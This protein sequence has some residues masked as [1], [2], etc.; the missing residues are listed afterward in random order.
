MLPASLA[1][2]LML[3]TLVAVLLAMGAALVAVSGVFW[4]R[5]AEALLRAELDEE[6]RDLQA[7]LQRH[8]DAGAPI[9]LNRQNAAI[10]DAMPADAAYRVLDRHGQVVIQSRTGSALEALGKPSLRAHVPAAENNAEDI[11][12]QVE[13]RAVDIDGARYDIQVARSQRLVTTLRG[14]AGKQSLQAAA[15]TVAIALLTFAAAIYLTV[16]RMVRPIAKVSQAAVEIGPRSLGTRLRSDGLPDELVPLIEAFNAALSRLENGYRVQQEFLAAAAHELKTPLALLRAEI[17]LGGVADTPRLLRDTELMARQV[18]QLLHL[19]EVS[20]GQ[21]YDMVPLSLRPVLAD[22]AGY[23]AGWAASRDVEIVLDGQSGPEPLQ[24]GDAAA[25]FVLA[26]NLL[27]N[28]VHHA[29]PGSAV[30]IGIDAGGFAVLDTGPGVPPDDQPRLF[31]R[32]WR[33]KTRHA[34]GAG[35]GLAICQEICLAHG[36]RISLDPSHAPGARFQV[37]TGGDPAPSPGQ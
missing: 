21:S 14:Y 10:Y 18:H 30:R 31:E 1:G 25:I 20:E 3:A 34:E 6:I 2:R 19:A 5:S 4:P 27:E 7:A 29:P 22:A 37:G 15:V 13:R 11:V 16:R 9:A 26:K 24:D 33:G 36:W 35:L 17:E 32:F 28:A 8:H 23:L 12:L